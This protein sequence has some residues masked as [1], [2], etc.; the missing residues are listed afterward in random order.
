MVVLDL[1]LIH[2]G[3]RAL[4]T[5]A[6]FWGSWGTWVF[7]AEEFSSSERI[8]DSLQTH[9]L[10]SPVYVR[11]WQQ[12]RALSAASQ[13]SLSAFTPRVGR[14]AWGGSEVRGRGETRSKGCNRGGKLRIPR[15]NCRP[16]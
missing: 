11:R 6:A 15:P 7:S 1:E 12:W 13:L 10:P 2:F 8:P 14:L 4:Y 9:I 3:S 5:P 16:V